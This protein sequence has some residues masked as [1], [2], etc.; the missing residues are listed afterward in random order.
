MSYIRQW[1]QI[2]RTAGFLLG[3]LPIA[4]FSFAVLAT[5]FSAGIGLLIVGVGV[6][7]LRFGLATARERGGVWRDW[8]ARVDGRSIPV[9]TPPAFHTRPEHSVGAY[10]QPLTVRS[11]WRAMLHQG[12]LGFLLTLLTWTAAAVWAVFAVVGPLYWILARLIPQRQDSIGFSELLWP[13]RVGVDIDPLL[14][15]S[16]L[17]A[18]LGI[19]FL[20]TLPLVYRGLTKLHWVLARTLLG[21]TESDSLRRE[22]A[23]LES[24]RGAA[25]AAENR[26]LGQLERDLHD[27]PSNASSGSRWTSRR[28]NVA[29]R[30]TPMRPRSSW[31]MR[32]APRGTH[33]TNSARSPAGSRHRSS[34][35]AGS[36]QPWKPS[37]LAVQSRSISL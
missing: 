32:G 15:D 4:L 11:D 9:P 19:V 28:P 14:A 30:I 34:A 36:Q 2:P 37:Q 16:L 33:S 22:V 20:G 1:Q 27:G 13:Q 18:A 31:V 35:T 5:L 3:N 10:I 25:A 29:S 21:E 17:Y 7:I 26:T 23:S 8:V 6:V 12:L 24:S